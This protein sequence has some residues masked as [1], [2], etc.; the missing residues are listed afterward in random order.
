MRFLLSCIFFFILITVKTVSGQIT[1]V[2]WNF[3]NTSADNLVDVSSTS[4]NNSAC[5]ITPIGGTTGVSYNTF[6]GA[7]PLPFSYCAYASSGWNGGA[8]T[9]GWEISFSTIGCYNL[10]VS[11]KQQ[12]SNTGPRDFKI[13]YKIGVGGTYIDLPSATATCSSNMTSGVINCVQ[14]PAICENKAAVFLRWIMSTNTA[15]NNGTVAA[16]G[17]SRIDDIVVNCNSI[18]FYR[19]VKSGKWKD[20]TVWEYSPD[21]IAPFIPAD[22]VPTYASKTITI[23]SGHVVVIDSSNYYIRTCNFT[24]DEVYINTGGALRINGGYVYIN[25]GPLVDINVYGE[26]MDSLGYSATANSQ[27]YINWM[28]GSTW[29]LGPNATF[30]KTRHSTNDFFQNNYA[31]G[32][33]NIPATANWILRKTGGTNPSMN[34]AGMFYP[35]FILENTTGAFYDSRTVNVPPTLTFFQGTSPCTIYGNFII[36]SA[37][38]NAIAMYDSILTNALVI[39]GNLII[40]AS[41]NFIINGDS[42][43]LAGDLTVNGN[44]DYSR[45][46]AYAKKFIFNGGITQTVQSAGGNISFNNVELNKSGNNVILNKGFTVDKNFNF[47]N[48]KVVTNNANRVVFTNAATATNFNNTS[49]IEGPCNKT[50]TAA[51]TFP[52][53]KGNNVQP[54]GMSASAVNVPFWTENF[55]NGCTTGCDAASYSG[56]NGS[57]TLTNFGPTVACGGAVLSNNWFVSCAENGNA[58]AACGSSCAGNATLHVGSIAGSPNLTATCPSGDC[59]AYYDIGG[60]CGVSSLP[61]STQTDKRIESPIIDCSTQSNITLSFKFLSGGN[62]ND[63]PSL[64]FYDGV[65]AWQNLA[66]FSSS[67]CGGSKGLWQSFS[68]LLPQTADFNSNVQLAFRW[69]NDDDGN[70]N[71]VSFAVYDVTLTSS[72][73]F[74]AEYFGYTNPQ[75]LFGTNLQA[76]IDHI[77]SCEYWNL[78]RVNGLSNRLV[79]LTWDS[80][81]CD[82]TSYTDLIVARYNASTNQWRNH[83]GIGFTGNNAAGTVTSSLI[84]SVF[85]PYTLA[86]TSGLNPL[87]VDLLVLKAEAVLSTVELNWQTASEPMNSYFTIQKSKDFNTVIDVEKVMAKGNSTIGAV[88]KSIDKDPFEGVSYYRLKQTDY[89]GNST[90]SNWE[91]V[92]FYKSIPAD[93]LVSVNNGFVDFSLLNCCNGML[94]IKIIDAFGRVIVNEK[95][96]NSKGINHVDMKNTASGIYFLNIETSERNFTAKFVY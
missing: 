1:L 96:T 89:N 74:S 28:F 46:N 30:V 54:I 32:I 15:V 8:G 86:S 63:Y 23:Q 48:G 38:I 55:N 17:T 81:S 92:N 42:T 25:D 68:I 69:Q 37:G 56:L 19:T 76:G 78:L 34:T 49:F 70:G 43:T 57:W 4:P 65:S 2:E 79:T 7:S 88:Y 20:K 22:T 10:D 58:V 60:L 91:S 18:G 16:G 26:L 45:T 35:N 21:N 41:G 40:N 6:L 44:L 87:P 90:F 62:A 24:I 85:G 33:V 3:P 27:G 93:L 13:Q 64:W 11:S 5:V 29:V 53:G 77:S 51:F 73:E 9:K 31:G 82:V 95:V 94:N 83:G 39:Q 52:V 47:I 75:L 71:G 12:S 50:G 36:N 66:S 61:G 84:S 72:D 59:G 80:N 67:I 14:L